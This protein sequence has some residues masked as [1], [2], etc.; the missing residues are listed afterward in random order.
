MPLIV[1]RERAVITPEEV[2]RGTFQ[3]AMKE[4]RNSSEPLLI[5][6]VQ[7]AMEKLGQSPQEM[8]ADLVLEPNDTQ[9]LPKNNKLIAYLL[10][11][12]Q[13][14]QIIH[15]NQLSGADP[16]D[17]MEVE[18]LRATILKGTIEHAKSDKD[19]RAH[20]IGAFLD[21]C[22]TFLD[23]VLEVAEKMAHP[24]VLEVVDA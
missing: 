21:A 10:E 2:Y 22:P 11:L 8:M 3:D 1:A 9:G 18:E 16:F 13:D 20:M 24:A 7:R 12:L 23:E 17:G 6:G 4:L 15:D 14:A 5:S 19:L